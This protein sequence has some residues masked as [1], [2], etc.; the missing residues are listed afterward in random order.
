L[1][2]I[3]IYG[4]IIQMKKKLLIEVCSFRISIQKFLRSI[5]EGI[6]KNALKEFLD[7][8]E[9]YVSYL[10]KLFIR[11]IKITKDICCVSGKKFTSEMK[12]SCFK[13]IEKK[14]K[15]HLNTFWDI[16]EATLYSVV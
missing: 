8:T 14:L 6:V 5:N 11:E 13:K 9:I 3:I 4:L 10:Y 7:D 1:L 15:E 12:R 2:C 16:Y